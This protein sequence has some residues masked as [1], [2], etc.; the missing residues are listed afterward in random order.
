MRGSK[1]FLGRESGIALLTV[2]LLLV[3]ML[4]LMIGFMA[5]VTNGQKLSGMNN[6]QTRAFYGAEAG[7]ESLTANL[8][9]LFTTTYA[10]S[11]AQVDALQNTPP[12][13]PASSDNLQ[14]VDAQGN[15]AYLISYPKDANG[16]P[17]ATPAQIT[18][19]SSPYQGMT[20]IETQ[21]T[22]T[23]TA[24]TAAG[25]EAKLQRTLQTVGI[26]LFQFGV[27]SQTDL[28]FFAGPNFN[29]GGRVHTNGNLFLA[30]GGPA[31]ATPVQ[32][33]VNQLWLSQPVTA[34][35][36]VIRDTLEN[37][38]PIN[39]G[40]EHP[41]SVEIT[42]GGGAF[43][44]LQFGQ[45]SQVAGVGTAANSPTWQQVTASYNGNLRNGVKALPLTIVLV[46][47]GTAQ[48]VDTIRRPVGGEAATNPQ[49]LG[50]R[51]F[52]QASLR[53][54]ISDN[55]ADITGLDCVSGGAPFNLTDIAQPVANWTSANATALKARMIA[56]GTLPLPLA[57][58]GAVAATYTPGNGGG[59]GY[60]ELA[61]TPIITGY[62]KI[63]A[64]TSYGN[65]CGTWKDVTLEVLSLGYAGRNLNPVALAPPA[66]PALPGA[67]Q[68]PSACADPHP[69]AII[70]LERVRDN[71]S[72]FASAT[73]PCG[74]GGGQAPPLPSDYWPN[75]LFDTREGGRREATPPAPYKNL[76]TLGGTMNYVELDVNNLARWFNG[77]IGTSGGSTYDP[78]TAP[79]N[80]SVYFSDRR[81]N[82]AAPG[83]IP[84]AWPPRSPSGNETG[85]Y[86]FSDFVN[87]ADIN[88]CPNG[89]LDSG[90]DLDN[91]GSPNGFFT[92]GEQ[93]SPGFLGGI[94]PNGSS[95]AAVTPD[96][97]CPTGT[98]GINPWPG[99]YL[100][101]PGEARENPPALFRRAIKLVNG[102]NI[103]L[104]VCPGG[105][106]CGLSVATE[107]PMYV[108]GN[109][110]AN[111]AGNG[112]NDHYVAASVAADAV[113][114]LSNNWNDVNSFS[115][116]FNAG[117]RN[118]ATSWYR[119]GVL[120][121][122][123]LAFPI[124]A[125]DTVAL[126]GSQDF[127]TDGGVHNF[128]RFLENWGSTLNYTGSIVSLFYNRQAVGMYR[129]GQVY[130]PPTRG[131][132]FDTNFLN[133][134]LLPP[135]TPMLRDLNTT[136][137]TQL[138][139]PQQ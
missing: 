26:P 113:T 33:G 80:F 86:G 51:Y 32:T 103:N 58:S 36:D 100:L 10:P 90:E 17:K 49:V 139:L 65:P 130:S 126:D 40:S 118:G 29:F 56:N 124:P 61:G 98:F 135:R 25:S 18:S 5:M 105:V 84:G 133:P 102:S 107:N 34:V 46:G 67:Q 137:F 13:L 66:L 21:Y 53:V 119:M 129:G 14:F 115:A 70:R 52:A 48:P 78:V 3:L 112:F 91:L 92:Y 101:N 89:T 120:A 79:N 68:P 82:Y 27:Y 116:P 75:V 117:G 96:P 6:D 125:W 138:M 42:T 99:S 43:Q 81:G 109:Y 88:G 16:N 95:A 31:G 50:E 28:A 60:W 93:V 136:G 39:A 77:A 106:T 110:N 72:N 71:P 87:P 123:E 23:V 74:V 54:L 37:G 63:D 30:S 20:A 38:H 19:G 41:G 57:A 1:K 134:V 122:K 128:M 64:Q 9:T 97:N 15:P 108:Q 8:G 7:L 131:Y 45:G 59:D 114:L 73:G 4:A 104:P 44:A 2:L 35:G 127:G 55:P 47:S 11:G 62:I 76:V 121:G 12:V 85:E 132:Q 24:R 83:A 94:F 69:N 22:L 111:S